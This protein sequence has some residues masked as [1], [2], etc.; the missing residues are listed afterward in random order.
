MIPFKDILLEAMKPNVANT[1]FAKFGVRNASVLDTGTLRKYYMALVKKH[2]PDKG[3]KDEDMRWIN[4]AYDVL[5]LNAKNV[6]DVKLKPEDKIVN[7]EFRDIATKEVLDMGQCNRYEYLEI[8]RIINEQGMPLQPKPKVN[9]NNVE[10][11]WLTDT[12]AFYMSEEEYRFMAPYFE[13]FFKH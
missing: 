2:H 13:P 1:I 10:N 7:I 6:T 12:V 8:C 4:A 9:Y 5:S 3:G 11:T